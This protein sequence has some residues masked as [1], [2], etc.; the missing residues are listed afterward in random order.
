MRCDNTCVTG[1]IG[2]HNEQRNLAVA[3]T[4]RDLLEKLAQQDA[5]PQGSDHHRQGLPFDE[6]EKF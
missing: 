3:H 5:G 4:T 2:G 6:A 1:N